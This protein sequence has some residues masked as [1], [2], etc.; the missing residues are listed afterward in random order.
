MSGT[1]VTERDDT[2]LHEIGVDTRDL[3][4]APL[5]DG[6]LWERV[7]RVTLSVALTGY[8]ALYAY[9]AL[10]RP[11]DLRSRWF[12]GSITYAPLLIDAAQGRVVR[13]DDGGGSGTVRWQNRNGAV[14]ELAYD[15]PTGVDVRAAV[16]RQPYVRAHPGSV[17]YGPITRRIHGELREELPYELLVL[18]AAALIYYRP[19]PRLATRWGWAWAVYPVVGLPAYLLLSGSWVRTEPPGRDGRRRLD[20]L[21][22]YIVLIVTAVASSLIANHVY[23]SRHPVPRLRADYVI[24]PEVANQE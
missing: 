13:V 5:R 16:E 4:A 17:T 23:D 21:T 7:L 14:Y 12:S 22:V 18:S 10:R 15:E 24:P 1:G 20:G 2:A 3:D 8:L 11:L 6:P 9:D 19:R